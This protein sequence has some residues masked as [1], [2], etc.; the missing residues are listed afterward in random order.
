M[1]AKTKIPQA[2]KKTAPK[3]KPMER[4]KAKTRVAAELEAAAGNRILPHEILYRAACG[5][6]FKQRR[7]TITYYKSGANKGH[8]KSR[9]WIVE[10][11]YPNFN[12]QIDAAKA[13]APYYTPRLASSTVDAGE[14]TK[15]A[16]TNVLSE[17][18]K[19]LP[20]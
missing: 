14:N 9:E 12:E 10:D 7:L 15:E 16:L 2:P 11:Y 5:E 13:A 17:I 19:Q 18:A 1:V 3:P 20:G 6:C 4:I 8:E